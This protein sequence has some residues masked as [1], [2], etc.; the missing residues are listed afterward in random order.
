MKCNSF[1]PAY[2]TPARTIA[3]KLESP[4]RGVTSTPQGTK[5]PG[6]GRKLVTPKNVITNPFESGTD[7]LHLPTYMSPGFFTVA[8]T[9]ASEEKVPAS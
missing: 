7:D 3:D 4:R 2:Q 5:P 8:S 1:S 9:P 6:S